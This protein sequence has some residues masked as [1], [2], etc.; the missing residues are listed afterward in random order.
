L[1]VSIYYTVRIYPIKDKDF[2]LIIETV[3][4]TEVYQGLFRYILGF[5]AFLK[6]WF[7]AFFVVIKKRKEI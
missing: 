2:F 5:V 7:D 3:V 4:N 6:L 1:S